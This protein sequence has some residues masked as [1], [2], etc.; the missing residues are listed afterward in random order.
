MVSVAEAL[1]DLP[2]FDLWPYVQVAEDEW[3]RVQRQFVL[4]AGVSL[5]KNRRREC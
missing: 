3:T 1:F 5:G 2:D 4:Q